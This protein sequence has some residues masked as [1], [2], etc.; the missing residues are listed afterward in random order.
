[1]SLLSD[2]GIEGNCFAWGKAGQRELIGRIS[3]SAVAFGVNLFWGNCP[4]LWIGCFP[5]LTLVNGRA[6]RLEG[7]ITQVVGGGS[8]GRNRKNWPVSVAEQGRTG[9][10]RVETRE[11]G[12]H[13]TAHTT[14]RSSRTTETVVDRKEAV[15]AGILAPIFNVPGL[16]RV[17]PP[18]RH[19]E[20]VIVSQ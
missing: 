17:H 11:T 18:E 2:S 14:I 8:W 12:S 9:E 19:G 16:W 6:G 5:V 3:R 13:K 1:M 7:Y 15:S 10:N 20:T 4:L